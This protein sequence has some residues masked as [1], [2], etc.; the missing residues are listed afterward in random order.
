MEF[1]LTN[2]YDK[3]YLIRYYL[4][5]CVPQV[6]RNQVLKYQYKK[7]YNDS[8][9][10]KFPQKLSEKIQWIKLYDNNDLKTI[11][12]DKLSCKKY[13]QEHLPNLNMAK[14]YKEFDTVE[15]IDFTALPNEFVLKTNHSWKTNIYIYSKNN[16]SSEQLEN[17]KKYFKR[18]LSINYAY[19]S[20]YELH[21][22]NIKPKVFAEEFYGDIW[23]VKQYE[24]WCFNGNP[25]FIVCNFFVMDNEVSSY[26]QY[27]YDC[28]WKKLQFN[29]F[30]DV[31]LDE[32]P[33]PQNL[34]KIIE[35]SK[36]LSKSFKLVRI[37]F[38]ENSEKL[39]LNEITFTPCS[40]FIKYIGENRDLYYGKKLKLA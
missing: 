8:L 3:K 1:L 15:D 40:G 20:Y 18:A 7:F 21:Y 13:I 4:L 34:M 5:K 2:Y 16:V 10:L 33:K 27:I 23:S 14:L 11:L 28:E 26:K 32:I 29:L 24:V 39:Y 25:E 37:D 22:K 6:F 30:N 38:V 9:N 31:Q 19:W 36:I 12:S 35:Y 17:M